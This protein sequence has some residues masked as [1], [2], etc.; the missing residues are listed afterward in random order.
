MPE[1]ISAG[2]AAYPAAGT[3][4]KGDDPG[5]RK[6]RGIGVHHRGAGGRCGL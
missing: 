1:C 2:K 3:A 6:Q 4:G 5:S